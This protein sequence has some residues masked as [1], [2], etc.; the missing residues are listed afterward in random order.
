MESWKLAVVGAAVLYGLHNIFVKLAAGRVS[1]QLGGLI[2]EGT[3]TLFLFAYLI[4]W[5]AIGDK[6]IAP[7]RAGIGFSLLA[8]LSVGVGTSR[9]SDAKGLLVRGSDS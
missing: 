3:A 2:L 6:S 4:Y 7:T 1:D 9:P 8:G 5:W